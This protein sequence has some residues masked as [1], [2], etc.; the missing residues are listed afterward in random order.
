MAAQ[1]VIKEKGILLSVYANS[2]NMLSQVILTEIPSINALNPGKYSFMAH[3]LKHSDSTTKS[4]VTRSHAYLRNDI[5]KPFP[6]Y[7]KRLFQSEAKSRA[8][9][10]FQTLSLSKRGYAQN[11]SCENEFYFHE[12]KNSISDSWHRTQ[13]HFET[14][15]SGSSEISLRG[16]RDSC[17]WGTL[18]GDAER[19]LQID[20]YTQPS[21]GSAFK[22]IQHSHPSPASYAGY[23]VTVYSHAIK[24]ILTRKVSRLASF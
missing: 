10:E 15:A 17:V 8:I 21:R 20:L 22:T 1:I 6:S 9:C 13:P 5:N 18:S 14:E 24:L 7:P 19:E 4:I 2:A 11:L 16:R 12:N 23:S 3:F